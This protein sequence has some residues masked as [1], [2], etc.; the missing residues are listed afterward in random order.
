MTYTIITIAI[1]KYARCKIGL[2]VKVKITLALATVRYTCLLA[3]VFVTV[4][5]ILDTA[6]SVWLHA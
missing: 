2:L 6:K 4:T 5:V 3:A 1:V